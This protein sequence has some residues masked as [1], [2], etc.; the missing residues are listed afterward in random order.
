PHDSMDGG[1]RAK[2]DARAE[3]ISIK[4]NRLPVSGKVYCSPLV[5]AQD[6]GMGGAV[7]KPIVFSQRW[8]GTGSLQLLMEKQK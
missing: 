8:A 5:A 4:S 1:V 2:Q 6:K 7:A 3:S